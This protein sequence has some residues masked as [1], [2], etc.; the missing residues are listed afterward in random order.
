VPPERSGM[1]ASVTNTSREIGAVTGV[2]ILGSLVFSLLNS[3]LTTHLNQLTVP[4]SE[5][6][7]ILGF[8]SLIISFIET[9]QTGGNANY[10]S[11]GGIVKQVIGAAYESFGEGLHAALYLSAGLVI[12]AGLLAAVTLGTTSV[13]ESS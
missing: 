12:A 3:S 6:A 7:E 13:T 10:N 9:G 4:A 1:A 11:Y 8:K 2:A 5:K